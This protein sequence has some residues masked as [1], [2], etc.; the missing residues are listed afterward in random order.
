MK[1]LQLLSVLLLLS[2]FNS[3]AQRFINKNKPWV[4]KELQKYTAKPDTINA[5]LKITDTTLAIEVTS[6]ALK[7]ADF[8]YHFDAAGKCSYENV[9]TYCI[10]CFKKYLD[11]VLNRKKYKWK[12][13]NENQ[14][15]SK[16]S[17][18]MMLELPAEEN[19]LSYR[20]LRTNWTRELYN[21]LQNQTE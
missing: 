9:N 7:I 4:L 12:K 21:L 11:G 2:S 19:K 5:E 13:I 18:K 10:A 8:M 15:I 16:Y 17:S 3:F 14:Y 6:P 1:T 20:I